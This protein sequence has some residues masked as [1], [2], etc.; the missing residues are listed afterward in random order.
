MAGKQNLTAQS[1]FMQ[2]HLISQSVHN[3]N[4][5]FLL[6]LFLQI[7]DS[8]DLCYKTTVLFGLISQERSLNYTGRMIVCWPF[9]FTTRSEKQLGA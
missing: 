1:C 5:F 8:V 6:Q 7:M 3:I 4:H 2:E 9:C